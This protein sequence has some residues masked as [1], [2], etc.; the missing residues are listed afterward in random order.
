MRGCKGYVVVG[1]DGG[2]VRGLERDSVHCKK[3]NSE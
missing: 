2:N 3:K 1:E